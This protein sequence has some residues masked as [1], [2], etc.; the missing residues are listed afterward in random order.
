M[1]TPLLFRS[2]ALAKPPLLLVVVASVGFE[3]RLSLRCFV[4]KKSA[5]YF[6]PKLSL[7]PSLR[8]EPGSV[9]KDFQ[10]FISSVSNSD[11]YWIRI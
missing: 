10:R 9:T 7:R 11:P 8:F 2:K 1:V 5:W 4:E 3:L 6:E